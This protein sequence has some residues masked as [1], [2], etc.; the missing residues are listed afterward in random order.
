M[1]VQILESGEAII[2]PQDDKI[3]L[4][5]AE[6]F[7]KALMSVFNQGISRVVIDLQNVHNIDS[8][9]LGKILVFNKRIQ[10]KNGSLTIKNVNNEHVRNLF[11]ILRLPDIVKIEGM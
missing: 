5:N 9:G 11:R 10:E 4:T 6:E 3:M 2:T 1:D 7:K 8:T